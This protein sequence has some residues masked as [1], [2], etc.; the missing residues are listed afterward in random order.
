MWKGGISAEVIYTWDRI[1]YPLKRVK[2]T[3]I[4]TNWDIVIKE[5]SKKILEIRDKYGLKL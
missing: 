5:I 3:F 4:R 1:L 2:D